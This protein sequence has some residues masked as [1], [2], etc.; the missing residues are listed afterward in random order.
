MPEY[1]GMDVRP[2]KSSPPPPDFR[3]A[4]EQQAAASQKAVGAQTQANRPNI[5]TPFGQQQWALGPD[6]QWR[7]STG[8]TGGLGT[9]ADALQQ[10]AGQA[11]AN[12]FSFGQFGN[13]QTGDAARDQAIRGAYAQATSRLDPQ[14]NQREE[15]LRVRLA[16]QGLDPNSEAAQRAMQGFNLGRNDAYTSAMNSAI[17]QGT[18][19]GTA[20][21]SQNLAARQQAISEALR[22]RG[23]PLETLQQMQPLLAMPGFN[24]A[25]QAQPA[26]YLP[27]A[28]MQF[29][30]DMERAKLDQKQQAELWNAI[31][32][33]GGT[34]LGFAFGGP[35]GGAAGAGLADLAAPVPL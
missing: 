35:M 33:L 1:F 7:M 21:F 19:A 10:Q 17:G 15:Q 34:G 14:W 32:Q 20:A 4:A 22:Q 30:A 8:F 23:M 18:A 24:S 12:P 26:E 11:L 27:A 31:L 16:N 13:I 25:G 9:A 6:G 3:G 2:K 29:A 5:T 28:Q